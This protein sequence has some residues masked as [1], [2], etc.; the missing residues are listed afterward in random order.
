MHRNLVVIALAVALL[1][2]SVPAFAKGPVIS[3]PN[4]PPSKGPIVSGPE[5]GG[6]PLYDAWY[7][8]VDAV[9]SRENN[10]GVVLQRPK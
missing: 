2:M 3:E 4:S 8:L 7:W 6:N 10:P 5:K 1:A 9:M